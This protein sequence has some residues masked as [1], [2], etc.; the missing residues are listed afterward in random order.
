MNAE[1]HPAIALRPPVGSVTQEKVGENRAVT[2]RSTS[3]RWVLLIVGGCFAIFTA[4]RFRALTSDSF[5]TLAAG[6]WVSRHGLPSVDHLTVA[7]QG[8]RWIDVEWLGQWLLYRIWEIGGY[9]LIA[10][11]AALL[12]TISFG[13]LARILFERGAHPRRVLKWTV[14]ALAAAVPDM[15]IRSQQFAYPLFAGLVWLLLRDLE[16]PST[17]RAAGA[18]AIVVVWANLHGSVLV[19]AGLLVAYGLWRCLRQPGYLMLA[20]AAAAS[21]LATPYGLRTIAYYRSVLGNSAIRHFSSEWQPALPTNLPAIGFFALVCAVVVS[22]VLGLRHDWRPPRPLFIAT[23]GLI[24][25]GFVAMRWEAWAAFPAVVLACDAL[26]RAQ[27]QS[28]RPIPRWVFVAVPLVATAG[29]LLLV[30]EQRTTF[31]KGFPTTAIAQVRAYAKA[32]PASLVLAD[33]HSSD[34]LLWIEPRLEGRVAFDDRLEVFPQRQ[35]DRWGSFIRGHDLSL[36]RGYDVL[37]VSNENTDL[38]KRVESLHGWRLVY[39]G[40]N[41]IVAVRDSA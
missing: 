5:M 39:Q 22:V 1:S 32:H 40:A 38:L 19:G 12:P 28:A 3:D 18:L 31:E 27:P 11:A 20:I 30:T 23:L 34:A 2:R 8:R 29:L 9:P 26:N 25:A 24:I 21:P 10:V 41:G 15:A 7:G 13:I 4:I 6:R 35:V 17:R 37:L 36:V 33:D 14:L 16:R